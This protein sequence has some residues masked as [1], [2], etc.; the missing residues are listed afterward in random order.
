[1]GTRVVFDTNVLISSLGWDAKPESCLERSLYGS[2]EG[3]I[4]P[5]LVDELERVL[6]YPHLDITAEEADSFVEVILASFH[7]VDPRVDFEVIEADPDDDAVLECAV[8]ADAAYI[9]SGDSHLQDLDSFR[10]IDIVS[11]AAFLSAH[12]PET[13]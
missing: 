13:G 12:E 7:L 5:D 8:A 11:P 6:E 2:D 1:M 9:V 4:S 3:Y 10:T